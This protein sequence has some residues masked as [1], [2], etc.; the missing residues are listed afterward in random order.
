MLGMIPSHQVGRWLLVNIHQL[1]DLMGLRKD[2]VTESIIY[3][4]FITL[5]ALLV[6]WLVRQLVL[7]IARRIVKVRKTSM[8]ERLL[9]DHVLSKC[10][11]IIPPLVILALL[12]F[13]FTTDSVMHT[14]FKRCILVYTILTFTL[15]IGSIVKFTF[16]HYNATRNTKG[17]P[18]A[19]I[20]YTIRGILWGIA[21]ICCVSVIIDKSPAYLLTGLGAFAAALMLIFKDSILGFVAGIQLAQNDMVRIGDWINVPDTLANGYVLDISLTRVKVQNWDYTIVTLPPYKLVQGSFQN[22]RG[23]ED[24]GVRRITATVTFDYQSVR[25]L[26]PQEI[27]AVASKLPLLAPYVSEQRKPDAA[28]FKGGT[29]VVNGTIDTNIG[30][31]RAYMCRYIL[32]SP[33]F[34]HDYQLLVH[35]TEASH[36]GMTVQIY[37]FACTARWTEYD[38]IASILIEHAVA[39]APTFGLSPYNSPSGV[40]FRHKGDDNYAPPVG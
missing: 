23:M 31:W 25:P 33:L 26:T 1:L 9:H 27:D 28:A 24:T 37:C 16:Q 18:I 8:G 13:A 6:G 21:F 3:V 20:L 38:A 7:A 39:V 29:D 34:S 22:Y 2:H 10:S 11:H 30:L 5:L 40:D 17:L 32:T 15:A 36:Q 35:T 4:I 14:V 12:P 19:G